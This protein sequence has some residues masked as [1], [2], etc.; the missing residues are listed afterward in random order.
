MTILVERMV[1]LSIFW[2][3]SFPA[4]DSVSDE[5]SPRQLMV[6][7]KLDFARHCKIE[8]GA[9]AQVH[10]Q[11][12]STMA[13]RTTGAIALRPTGNFQRGH[14]FMS[15]KTP[16]PQS[17][18]RTPRTKGRDRSCAQVSKDQPCQQRADHRRSLR[19]YNA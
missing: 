13:A 5:M 10:E 9:Y 6:G 14:Y 12:N 4:H 7:F 15:L 2:L 17:L 18:D 3:N 11:H 1:Q 8:F 16:K 19:Q